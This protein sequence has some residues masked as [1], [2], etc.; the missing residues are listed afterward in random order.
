MLIAAKKECENIKNAIVKRFK[1]N[2]CSTLPMPVND[3][4]WEKKLRRKNK[5]YF[6]F[7]DSFH[8]SR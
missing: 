6:S 8:R 4:F 2:I 5:T 1:K 7:H 3:I